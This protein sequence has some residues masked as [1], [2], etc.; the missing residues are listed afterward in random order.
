MDQSDSMT[1]QEAADYIG[2]T[3]TA[4]RAAVARGD[5]SNFR[6]LR[7]KLKMLHREDVERYKRGERP[8]ARKA[9][10]RPAE[11][12]AQAAPPMPPEL[13][14]LLPLILA[15]ITAIG[16]RFAGI[17]GSVAGEYRASLATFFD[18]LAPRQSELERVSAQMAREAQPIM[19]RAERE[20]ATEEGIAGIVG[21]VERAIKREGPISNEQKLML[22][23]LQR[24]SL[25][26]AQKAGILTVSGEAPTREPE[27]AIA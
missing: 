19:D 5:I 3:V 26:Y 10:A 18:S 22:D 15:V 8:N 16:E 6:P 23:E 13:A 11:Q 14:A 27:K 20:G 21:I 25:Q 2:T 1:Y 24:M 9:E 12:T 17:A 7:S 4:L